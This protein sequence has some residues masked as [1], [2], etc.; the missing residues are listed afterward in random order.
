[1]LATSVGKQ[2]QSAA[3]GT[4]ARSAKQRI[5]SASMATERE[6]K[7]RSKYQR[8]PYE[9]MA[10]SI[11]EME[12]LVRQNHEMYKKNQLFDRFVRSLNQNPSVAADVKRDIGDLFFKVWTLRLG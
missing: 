4:R 6:T 1:M 9:A 5:E 7:I 2:K 10:K 12:R 3:V 11:R 8:Q